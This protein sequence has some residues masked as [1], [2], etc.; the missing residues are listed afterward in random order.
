VKACYISCAAKT[1]KILVKKM[2][3]NEVL[4]G[5]GHDAVKQKMKILNVQG[6]ISDGAAV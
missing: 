2:P 4:C 1:P 5:V 3:M 6:I